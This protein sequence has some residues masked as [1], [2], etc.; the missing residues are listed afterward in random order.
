MHSDT[1]SIY[2]CVILRV[3]GVPALLERAPRVER[4]RCICAGERLSEEE[5]ASIVKHTGLEEDLD[6]NVK[7]EG[8]QR[9][10]TTAP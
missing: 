9:T 6:G 10:A 7:Y 5:V 4:R 8:G 1:L 2:L 3:S